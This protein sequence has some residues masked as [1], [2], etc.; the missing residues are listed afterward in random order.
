M[1]SCLPQ[2]A[3]RENSTLIFQGLTIS[4]RKELLQLD[5]VGLVFCFE[6]RLSLLL[7]MTLNF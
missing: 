7:R 4:Y 3:S 2:P 6:R 5:S 1:L